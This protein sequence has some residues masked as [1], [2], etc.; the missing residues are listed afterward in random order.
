METHSAERLSGKSLTTFSAILRE[1]LSLR[2]EP[3]ITPIFTAKQSPFVF[4][5]IDYFC[6][7][8]SWHSAMLE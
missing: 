5:S 3:T 2:N 7:Q 6:Q 1:K 4:F 8:T